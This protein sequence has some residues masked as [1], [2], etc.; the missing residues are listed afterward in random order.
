MRSQPDQYV[1]DVGL[2]TRL[3]L[4]HV[5]PVKAYK[6]CISHYKTAGSTLYNVVENMKPCHALFDVHGARPD[7][8][9]PLYLADLSLKDYH[10]DFQPM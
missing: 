1:K 2:T 10:Q 3:I 5:G 8:D 4:D 9:A 7:Q 6:R